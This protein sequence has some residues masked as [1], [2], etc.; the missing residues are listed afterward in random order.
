MMGTSKA[1]LEVITTLGTSVTGT[2]RANAKRSV[3][4][5]VCRCRYATAAPTTSAD[6]NPAAWEIAID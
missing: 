5:D 6:S 2:R 3:T 4:L 1:R